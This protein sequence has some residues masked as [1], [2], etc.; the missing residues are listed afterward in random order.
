MYLNI[1]VAGFTAYGNG[2]LSQPV[3]VRTAEDGKSV[4]RQERW[5]LRVVRF[6][7]IDGYAEVAWI[8]EVVQMILCFSIQKAL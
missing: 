3:F 4:G 8:P 5:R 7:T 6:Q 1:T 2:P